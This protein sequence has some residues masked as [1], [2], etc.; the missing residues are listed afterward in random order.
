MGNCCSTRNKDQGHQLG[1]TNDSQVANGSGTGQTLSQG[2]VLGSASNNKD[3]ML[4]AAEKRRLKA[5]SRGVQNGGGSLNK[6]LNDERGKKPVPDQRT[7]E[8]ELVWD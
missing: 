1:S 3:A 4:A 7:N 5:E 2:Q 6:K 8:P